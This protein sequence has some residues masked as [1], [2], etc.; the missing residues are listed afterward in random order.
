MVQPIN[1]N[2][3][4]N[5]SPVFSIMQDRKGLSQNLCF[6]GMVQSLILAANCRL[7]NGVTYCVTWKAAEQP[8][9]KD[10]SVV[11]NLGLSCPGIVSLEVIPC[12]MCHTFLCIQLLYW[13]CRA[14]HLNQNSSLQLLIYA[15]WGLVILEVTRN[16][17][18][19][20]RPFTIISFLSERRFTDNDKITQQLSSE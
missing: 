9:Q 5:S 19:Y 17:P 8:E 15:S 12:Q 14:G 7:Q 10:G 18:V 2:K 16:R 4:K 11:N 6:Q 13:K 1:W 3:C 20:I